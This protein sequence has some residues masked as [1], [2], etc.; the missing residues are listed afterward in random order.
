MSTSPTGY[1]KDMKRES[2]VFVDEKTLEHG[3][4]TTIAEDTVE[5]AHECMS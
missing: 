4:T 2:N 5:A 1:E 3:V